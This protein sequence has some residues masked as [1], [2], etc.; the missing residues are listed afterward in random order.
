MQF[1]DFQ[2]AQE[3]N[4][5]RIQNSELFVIKAFTQEIDRIVNSEN[6]VE[7]PRVLSRFFQNRVRTQKGWLT[8]LTK[9]T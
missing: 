9:N 1:I 2:T 8:C 4:Y 6:W 3:F 5:N 7:H